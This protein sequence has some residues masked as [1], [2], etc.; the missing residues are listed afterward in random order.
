MAEHH[1]QTADV[2]LGPLVADVDLQPRRHQ[3]RRFQA[4]VGT[5]GGPLAVPGV[6][7]GQDG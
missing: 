4:R 2:G 1:H 3:G 6:L 5:Q 7:Q